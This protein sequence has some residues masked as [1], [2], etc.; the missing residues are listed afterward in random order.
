MSYLQREREWEREQQDESKW[1]MTKEDKWRTICQSSVKV[2]VSFAAEKLISVKI[3]NGTTQAQEKKKKESLVASSRKKSRL[4][5]TGALKLPFS[6]PL[7]KVT[8]MRLMEANHRTKSPHSSTWQC[9]I[10]W[11]E[12]SLRHNYLK[13]AISPAA[14]NPPSRHSGNEI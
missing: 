3:K 10:R 9:T 5:N 14:P 11:S 7:H 12:G 1:V 8:M 6:A 2:I 13:G 4:F